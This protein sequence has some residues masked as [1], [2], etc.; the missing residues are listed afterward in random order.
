MNIKMTD[1]TLKAKTQT[2]GITTA[3][4]TTAFVQASLGGVESDTVKDADK[5]QRL[6]LMFQIQMK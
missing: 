1:A 4:A 2:T 3:V 5:I 6:K